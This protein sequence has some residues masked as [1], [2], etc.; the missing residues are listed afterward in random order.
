MLNE[1]VL[2]RMR[3][4]R[5]IVEGLASQAGVELAREEVALRAGR[6]AETAGGRTAVL[7]DDGLGDP[8]DWIAAARALRRQGA[9]GVWLAA[10]ALDEAAR[11]LVAG[12]VDE[13]LTVAQP[14]PDGRWYAEDDAVPKREGPACPESP[15]P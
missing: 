5:R 6:P 3:L 14:P 15:A 11:A 9:T 4:E 7:V 10:P 1:S 13:I 2:R 8:G 12:A